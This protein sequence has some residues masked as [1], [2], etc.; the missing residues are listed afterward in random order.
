MLI[1]VNESEYYDIFSFDPH[2]F[3]SKKFIALNQ[4]KVDRVIRLIDEKNRFSLG[5]ILGLRDNNLL[6]PFSAPFGGF[7]FCHETICTGAIRDFIQQLRDFAKINGFNAIQITLPP[8][9]YSETLNSKLIHSLLN[10]GFKLEK[11]D[12]TGWVNLESFE[13]KFSNQKA[14]QYLNQA[15]RKDLEFKLVTKGDEKLSAFEIIKENRKQLGR[16]I[17]MSFEDLERVSELWDVDYFIVTDRY[18]K[19]LASAIIYRPQKSIAYAVFWGDNE[20]GRSM[21]AMNFTIFNL[22]KFYKEYG[23]K[24]IDIGIST[25]NGIPN[26]GLLWFKESHEATS[27]LRY[28]FVWT[29]DD[30]I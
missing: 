24:Y 28:T 4:H 2:P 18:N 14:R 7:N 19:K 5:L 6:S 16:P 26:D 30:I 25:E 21:R 1:D 20:I 11:L 9:I 3:I 23:F 29:N 8:N 15:L 27:S 12:I 22:W 17:Y 10:E 13:Y